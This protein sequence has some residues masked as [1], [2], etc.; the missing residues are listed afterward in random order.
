[1]TTCI[2]KT[3]TEHLPLFDG[4][5]NPSVLDQEC[6]RLSGQCKT[7]FLRLMKGPATNRELQKLT[8]SLNLSG[9]LSDVRAEV[10]KCHWE[11]VIVKR[12]RQGLNTYALKR[13]DGTIHGHPGVSYVSQT[14]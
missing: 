2:N 7:I 14:R 3:K 1:M 10:Q 11:L 9:R 6:S 13:P 12:S 8:Q 5:V 4:I